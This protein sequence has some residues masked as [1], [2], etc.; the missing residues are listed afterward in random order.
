MM[1]SAKKEFPVFAVDVFTAFALRNCYA[2]VQ[3]SDT[4]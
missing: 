2:K 4:L 1:L 3:V